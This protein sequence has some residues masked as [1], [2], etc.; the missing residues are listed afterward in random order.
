MSSI[1]SKNALNTG[2]GHVISS[3]LIIVSGVTI[4][5]LMGWQIKYQIPSKELL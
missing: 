5:Q 1:L 2:H 3:N 4:K